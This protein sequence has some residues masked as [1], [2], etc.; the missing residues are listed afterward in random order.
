MILE[1]GFQE[2]I[3]VAEYDDHSISTKSSKDYDKH[4]VSECDELFVMIFD[5]EMVARTFKTPMKKV[6][7]LDWLMGKLNKESTYI[8]LVDKLKDVIDF[9]TYSCY[10]A[11][12]GIGIFRLFESSKNQLDW[13][14]KV[15]S[16]LKDNDIVYRCEYSDARWVYRFVISKSV[17]NMK[18]IE[19]MISH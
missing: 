1:K 17:D 14:V 10:P 19:R 7:G 2:Y 8:S 11:S 12:Y 5:G 4:P 16:L 13:Y 9:G 3:D 15:E 18:R 6:I